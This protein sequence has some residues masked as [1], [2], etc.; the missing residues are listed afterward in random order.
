MAETDDI[1]KIEQ[2]LELMDKNKLT[3]IEIKK[4]DEKIL[5][6]RELPQPPQVVTAP[7]MHAPAAAP[8]AGVP[9]T[10]AAPEA[11]EQATSN[12]IDI[13]APMVGT[14]YATPSPD[15]DAYVEI[16]SKVSEQDVV[17]II[18]AMK[19]MNEIKAETEGTIAE[20]CV[21]SGQAVEYG[22]V[23]YRVE[24]N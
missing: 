6:K 14:Y 7:V 1:K 21:E 4:G 9:A 8:T 23:L 22:Q 19:V 11:A 2:L 15:S 10:G 13:K 20:I 18:E 12:L 5:L 17:C 3:E 16:G 24:P